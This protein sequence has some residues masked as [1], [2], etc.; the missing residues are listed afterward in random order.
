[1]STDDCGCDCSTALESVYLFVDSEIE[2]A[3]A[4]EIQQHLETCAE[5]LSEYDYERLVK[6]L[7]SRSCAEVAPDQL[8]ERVLIS[9]RQEITQIQLRQSPPTH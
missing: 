2:N 6:M 1:M 5:C 8:R 7:V 9:I 4:A 3:S